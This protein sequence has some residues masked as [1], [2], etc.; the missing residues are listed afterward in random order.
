[1]RTA[2]CFAASV[3]LFLTG[4]GGKNQPKFDEL[5]PVTGTLTAG[6]KAVT[7]G[8]VQF[9]P[10]PAKPEFMVNSEVGAD[11]TFRL[12]TV[13]TTDSKGERKPGAPAGKYQ[14]TY[15]PPA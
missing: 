3:L 5:H 11:G 13:R 7:G 10:D 9:S 12:S 6:G 14:V 8:A 2:L 4:C 1:M 15:S